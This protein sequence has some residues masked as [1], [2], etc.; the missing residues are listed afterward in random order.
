MRYI[1]LIKMNK[2]NTLYVF[3][4]ALLFSLNSVAENRENNILSKQIQFAINGLNLNKPLLGYST[5]NALV[6]LGL[7]ENIEIHKSDSYWDIDIEET[8]AEWKYQGLSLTTHYYRDGLTKKGSKYLVPG[9]YYGGNTISE[10]KVFDKDVKLKLGLFIGDDKE[11]LLKTFGKLATCYKYYILCYVAKAKEKT[12]R[13]INVSF[14]LDA[15][16]K[17]EEITWSFQPWH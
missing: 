10:I 12:K 4:I 8:P 11:K 9:P 13:N 1:G 2:Y 6:T 5:K 17:I 15:N 14:K 7:P 16:D 3:L